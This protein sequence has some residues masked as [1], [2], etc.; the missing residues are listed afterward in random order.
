MTIHDLLRRRAAEAPDRPFLLFEGREFTHR[1]IDDRSTRVA[2]RLVRLGVRKGD[3]VAVVMDNRPEFFLA[4]LGIL[5]AGA[6]LVP[7]NPTL[8]PP[9]VEY[10][11]SN[12]EARLTITPKEF[13]AGFEDDPA[14]LPEV[15]PHD[16]AA[17]VYTSGTTG[18][19]KGA[20]LTHA[21]YLW[22]AEAIVKAA[23][24]T[25]EDRFVC[26]LPVFHVNAQVVTFLAPLVGGGSMVLLRR[27]HPLE[28]LEALA[29]T[30]ATA[31]SGVPTV[32]TILNQLPGAEKFDLSRLRFCICGAAPMPVEV[33]ETFE[34]KFRAR[35]LEGY[36]LTEATC[37][38]SINPL[39]RRKVGSIGVPLQGQE[40]KLVE[41]EI[42]VRGSNVMKGYWRNPE[43]TAEAI[44]D[45][46]LHTGDLGRIAADGYFV[47]SGRKQAMINRGGQKVWPKEIEE[48]LFAH[49]AVADAAV[50]G[51]ADP[52]YG[53]EVAAYVVRKSAVTEAEILDFCRGRLAEY[54]RPKAVLFRESLPKTATGKVQKHLLRG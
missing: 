35:I 7:V 34:R 14:T 49:P 50:A 48:V 46:W 8:T 3:R 11:V 52:K 32:Y 53:E 44:R 36:G 27:F 18:K 13:E 41:G 51:V 40:M 25:P 5:K 47:N 10:I 24:M 19:P 21:N 42:V 1:E 30:R 39:D 4:W 9:E 12:S 17:I 54:K 6:A 31:F 16:L 29:K 15:G 33:F 22:D 28:L 38:S 20:M 26:I 2:A 43:A 45:G 37:A 23:G